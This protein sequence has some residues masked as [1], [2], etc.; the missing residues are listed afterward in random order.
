MTQ[1]LIDGMLLYGGAAFGSLF[2]AW[3]YVEVY[4]YFKHGEQ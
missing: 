3:S 4:W 1:Y 2:V